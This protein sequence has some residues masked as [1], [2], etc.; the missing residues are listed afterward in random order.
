MKPKT[1]VQLLSNWPS[2]LS[3]QDYIES[4]INYIFFDQDK[5]AFNIFCFDMIRGYQVSFSL[6][7]PKHHFFNTFKLACYLFLALSR[8][9]KDKNILT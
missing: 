7:T 1:W 9:L 8:N 5:M 6:K 3:N 2:L 4:S